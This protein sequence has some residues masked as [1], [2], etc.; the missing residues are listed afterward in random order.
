MP[1][2]GLTQMKPNI[3]AE[4][5][6]LRIAHPNLG[7][8]RSAGFTVN[9]YPP[10][11]VARRYL[12]ELS[13]VLVLGFISFRATYT[14]FMRGIMRARRPNPRASQLT[15]RTAGDVLALAPLLVSFPSVFPSFGRVPR[16]LRFI[17][18][19]ALNIKRRLIKTAGR[20][21]VEHRQGCSHLNGHLDQ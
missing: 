13:V 5:A 15:R 21:L 6:G 9:Q 14:R 16:Q 18:G 12:M 19:Q 7:L 10:A 8:P 2:V 3:N 17:A 20:Y 4:R 1:Y 11:A